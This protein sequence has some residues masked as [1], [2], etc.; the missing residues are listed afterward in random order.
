MQTTVTKP[1]PTRSRAYIVSAGF[2]EVWDPVTRKCI[3]ATY[4]HHE[5]VRTELQPDPQ[6]GE[7]H[8]QW[9]HIF[10]CKT[11]GAERVFGIEDATRITSMLQNNESTGLPS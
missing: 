9:A 8:P 7:L 6:M 11:T 5:Y 2:P 3:E 4:T 10:R 1:R